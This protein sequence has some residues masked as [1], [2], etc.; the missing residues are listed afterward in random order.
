MST[1]EFHLEHGEK[2]TAAV[3]KHWFVFLVSLLPF[4]LLAWGPLLLRDFFIGAAV[5]SPDI[6]AAVG[7]FFAADNEWAR[8][9]LGLWWLVLWICAFNVFTTYYLDLW[10]ITTN[11]IVYI[12]QRGFFRREVSSFLL[13][14]VQDV[15]SSIHGFFPTIIGYGT[16]KVET[17]GH[18][19][20][21]IMYGVPHP[22]RLRDLVMTEI[23]A[24]H[25]DGTREKKTIL[26]RIL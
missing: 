8:L 17:A 20:Q 3:R 23:A 6:A 16:L 18:E 2:V 25:A 24:L 22:Q 9:L 4:A 5:K 7:P 12:H 15:S 21:F 1:E 10:I 11:R 13:N 26:E 14:R 19:E